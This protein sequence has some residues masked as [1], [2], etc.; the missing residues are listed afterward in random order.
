MRK[1]MLLSITVI[2]VMALNVCGI[3][4]AADEKKP[5]ATAPKPPIAPGV[6]RPNL[7]MFGGTIENIDRSDP[8]NIKIS[9]KSETDGVVHNLSVAPFTNITKITDASELKTGDAVRVMARKTEDNKETAMGILFGKIRNLPPMRPR[10]VPPT[11]PQIPAKPIVKQG[12]K[13]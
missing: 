2:A 10:P 8:A 6:N 7:N 1:N 5:M 9:V 11:A 13:K 3:S 12:V 4:L